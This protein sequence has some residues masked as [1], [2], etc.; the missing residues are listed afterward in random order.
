MAP[1]DPSSTS[2]RPPEVDWDTAGSGLRCLVRWPGD[3]PPLSQVLPIFDQ[4]SLPLVDHRP[5]PTADAFFFSRLDDPSVNDVLPLL[6]EAFV[7]AWEGSVDRD[8]FASLVVEA[9]LSARQ[10]QLVRA[11]CQYLRQ[12][13]LGAS[14][15]YVRRILS[16]HREFVRTGS[17]PSRSASRRTVPDRA[18]TVGEVCRRCRDQGRVPGAALVRRLPGRGH[19]DDVLP[20]RR[21]QAVV[22]DR[23]Q[24]RPEHGCRSRRIRVCRW[25]LCAPSPESRGCMCVTGMWP[26]AGCAG[27]TGSRTTGTRCSPSRRPSR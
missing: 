10:V 5:E 7:M 12:A 26:E 17:R 8:V 14:R 16:A 4:L 13:G 27:R 2:R 23:V 6:T 19:A 15:P 21:R 25:R 24:G 11:G 3:R 1:S 18:G 22:H 20:P 9:Q